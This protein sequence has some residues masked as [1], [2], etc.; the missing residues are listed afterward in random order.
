MSSL[1]TLPSLNAAES[2][3]RERDRE[4]Q[5]IAENFPEGALYQYTVTAENQR[6]LSYAGRG[7]ERIFGEVPPHVP[8]DISWLSAR[9][10]P[11][12]E[13]AIAAAGET[14]HRELS[15]FKHEVRIR[16][17]KGG[18]RWVS[19]RSQP[20]SQPDGSVIWDGAIIDVT[21][22]RHAEES[23]RRQAEFLAALHQS[24]LELVARRN[25]PELLQALADRAS[26]L[27][28]SPHAEISLLEGG[29]LVVRAY[30]KGRDYLANDVVT[31]EEPAL[32]WRAI[33]TRQPVVVESY[34]DN[35][36]SREVY[37]A[38]GVHSA[39]VFPIFR[40]SECAGVLGV[41]RE[42]PGMP[43]TAG[44]IQEGLLLA[45][46]AALVLH[47]AAIHEDAVR[48]AEAR[49]LALR[50]SEERF[51][52]VFDKSPMV[53]SLLTVPEGRIVEV[54][55]AAA[56]AFGWSREEAV[57]RTSLEL[58]L[59]V[60]L[61]L[62][63]RYLQQLRAHG[64]A[65][66][67]EAEMRRKNGDTFTVLYSGSIV[68]IAGRPYSL[69]LLQDI[70]ARK[71]S[72]AARERSLS[73]MRAT[74][75]STADGILVV[76][77]AGR[78]ETYNRNFAEMWRL[79]DGH[80]ETHE[81]DHL[82][83]AILAQLADPEK[84]LVSVRDI[85]SRSEEEVF[86]ELQLK[87]GRILERYSRPQLIGKQVVGRVWS[88]RDIT[89]RRLAEAALRESEERFRVLAD[90]SPVGIFS[91]DPTG[92][93]TFVNRRWCEIAGL[94]L[95]EA[96]G[97]G[98]QRALHPDDRKTVA[99]GWTEA[100]QEGHSSAAE[101]R[102][103]RPDGAITW[104]V[105]Q[106]RAQF[107][108]AGALA[109]YVGT[110]TDVTNLKRADEERK[111]IEAQL[112]Q[113]RK[114]ESL[115]TL[116][117]GIA[118]DFNNILNGTFG[119][120]D[121][122]RL[123]LVPGHPAHAWL[124]RIAASSQRARELIRQILTFSRKN[125]GDRVPQRLNAVVTEALR[126]LRSSLPPSIALESRVA[127][128]T[129]AVMA[130]SSQ[131]HQVVL[132]LCTNAW[133]AM[134]A[135]GGRI[136]VTLGGCTVTPAEVAAQPELRPGRW[137]RLAVSD[138]GCG[139]DAATMEHIFEPFFT[140]KETGSG[141][142]LGLAVVHGIVK[143]HEGAIVV[144]TAPGTGSTFELY[145]PPVETAPDSTPAAMPPTPRGRG[146]RVLVVDDD[147]VSGFAV[148][149][150]VE[151]LGYITTRCMRPEEALAR[152][153]AAPAGFDL[154]VTDLA[155]PGM[156]GDELIEHLVK[157]R[158]DVPIIVVSG[159]IESARQRL[160]EK[161]PARAILR[162]PVSRDELGRAIAANVKTA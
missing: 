95:Q 107:N 153:T 118:H 30:S 37:R 142:G 47:N 124:D 18:E 143:S 129:P 2:A 150:L 22:R 59:W 108:A 81:E 117:G 131:I 91:S 44:D 155:M 120:V 136:E 46:M 64:S 43:F 137:V 66:S 115:G 27:L 74:L 121:L 40:G 98:W 50:E 160:L 127:A 122:A 57:G 61:S 54:N 146:E 93:C 83:R 79:P 89:K 55:A 13:P 104:L 144:R 85:Y 156:N 71:Q 94:S 78:V 161:S 84:F 4:L 154:V 106:S 3:L 128:D 158:A 97:D 72:E 114:M 1:P 9:I 53:I 116:A 96:V 73:Q 132:N 111:K 99:D 148:E 21:E 45:Q 65:T 12:D 110:I 162:K 24:T 41:A 51:R 90:V 134:P 112:R 138:D 52:G 33:D 92:R 105:G 69:N 123:E 35:P 5:L 8:I 16:S 88:F 23:V 49:T 20:R 36:D 32:S 38:R 130:D 7:F 125:E 113:S 126:L 28:R 48:E 19:I 42:R 149:K 39:A 62:R 147:P 152:F 25:V 102:F 139:I 157:V 67:F 6:L 145:F 141:T 70:T 15:P 109:G 151:S 87:D 86:D 119:F 68:T 80:A 17:A 135:K 56:A 29:N 101:F 10:H 103:V 14:S 34:R 58:N 100:V 140:T 26:A 75:E 82:L 77:E 31:R 159:Y 60:D 76:N 11:D 133:H 63:E